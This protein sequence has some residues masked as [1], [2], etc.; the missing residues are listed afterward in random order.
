MSV[1]VDNRLVVLLKSLRTNNR[2]YTLVSADRGYRNADA[3][4][5]L[6]VD[7]HLGIAYPCLE[8]GLNDFAVIRT[9]FETIDVFPDDQA[10]CREMM[11]IINDARRNLRLR[12]TELRDRIREGR[13]HFLGTDYQ[14]FKDHFIHMVT[15][16]SIRRTLD[17]MMK[18]DVFESVARTDAAALSG[19]PEPIYK[20]T[21]LEP[22][23]L[24]L[25]EPLE[26]LEFIARLFEDL[27][28]AV[29]DDRNYCSK[30]NFDCHVFQKFIAL[31]FVNYAT[32]DQVFY[33]TSRDDY[34][35][36]GE[37]DMMG[38]PLYQA[39]ARALRDLE[40]GIPYR[41]Q[42]QAILDLDALTAV[43]EDL[44]GFPQAG[45]TVEI[46]FGAPERMLLEPLTLLADAVRLL[47]HIDHPR[48]YEI[49]AV[50]AS[51]A[52]QVFRNLQELNIISPLASDPMDEAL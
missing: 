38:T 10:L 28:D 23:N 40:R 30:Y 1:A 11:E 25:M 41:G 8:D 9:T 36:S 18:L 26:P 27:L 49:G 39:I 14:E 19:M 2:F 52:R 3:V 45:R 21:L 4:E 32:T 16:G 33:G 44:G 37:K 5:E 13:A 24:G 50:A 43:G 29:E 7:L 12:I 31:M 35:V 42:G 48:A 46:A 17:N 6:P 47:E 15:R 51:A 20:Y 22:H 34:G